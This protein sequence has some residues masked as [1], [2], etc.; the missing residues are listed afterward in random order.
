MVRRSAV[1]WDLIVGDEED[2]TPVHQPGGALRIE[3]ARCPPE[4]TGGQEIVG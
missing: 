1:G 2:R 4:R 3:G